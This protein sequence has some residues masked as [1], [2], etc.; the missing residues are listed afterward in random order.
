MAIKNN[1][2]DDKTTRGL[3]AKASITIYAP[4]AKVWDAFVN[5]EMIK[6]YMFGT[7]VI[8][9]WITGSSIVWQG[10]WQGKQYV[11][12]GTILK[13]KKERIIQYSHYSSLSGKPDI[14]DNYHRVTVELSNQ[15]N[16]TAILLSQDNNADE[17]DR[18]HSEKNWKMML[19]S[20]KK[21]LE[22]LS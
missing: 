7:E 13:I 21:L 2:Q 22:K 18:E 8:S 12:K 1:L 14:P 10:K 5:P 16:Q 6:Q 17:Q 11:D 15:G 3:I 19:E 4:A 20:L 9:N